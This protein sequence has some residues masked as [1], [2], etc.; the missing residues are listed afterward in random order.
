MGRYTR[1]L[2]DAPVSHAVA[3][4]ILHEIT[5]I[6]PLFGLFGLFHYTNYVPIDY[7]MDHYGRQVVEGVQRFERYFRRK[8][9][10]GFGA[11]EAATGE[12][13]EKNRVADETDSAAVLQRWTNADTKYKIVVEVALAYAITKALLPIRIVASVSATPWFAGVLARLR[14]QR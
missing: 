4:M 11:D 9:W 10:F 6:V 7:M 12:T 13:D 1:R 14:G 2:Q 5:A 8:G 3:F